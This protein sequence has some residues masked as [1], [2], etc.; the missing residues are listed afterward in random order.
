[1]IGPQGPQGLQG[2]SGIQGPAGQDGQTGPQGPK[3]D[4]GTLAFGIAGPLA[5][6]RLTTVHPTNTWIPL[7]GRVISLVKMS[8]TSKLRITYM[9]TLGARATSFNACQWRIVVDGAVWAFFS[10]GDMENPTFGWRIHNSA[11]L[12]WAFN[13]P[14]GTHDIHVEGLRTPAAAECLSG[15]NT[16]GNFL[17]VEEIP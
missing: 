6:I 2:D 15:W 5:D 12:A 13:I 8:D 9:D 16:T 4:P 3:G 14:A 1:L 17:T 11:H 10:D 7:T